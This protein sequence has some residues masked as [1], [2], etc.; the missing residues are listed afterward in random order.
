LSCKKLCRWVSCVWVGLPR[1]GLGLFS[2]KSPGGP[3]VPRAAL[4][5]RAIDWQCA[6]M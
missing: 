3:I 6:V 2:G 5:R 4:S 1:G